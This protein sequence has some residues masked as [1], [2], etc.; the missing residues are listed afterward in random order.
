[1]FCATLCVAVMFGRICVVADQFS[2]QSLDEEVA[3][4]I[5]RERHYDAAAHRAG[6]GAGR[7]RLTS[8]T[9]PMPPVRRRPEPPHSPSVRPG[10][11]TS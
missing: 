10:R 8:G 5:Q 6:S 1:M 4:A 11:A 2:P 7:R 9:P 3:H